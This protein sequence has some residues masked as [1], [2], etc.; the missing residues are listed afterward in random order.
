[1]GAN[2][3]PVSVVP[4]VCNSELE[5][6]LYIDDDRFLDALVSPDLGTITLKLVDGLERRTLPQFRQFVT[7]PS[8]KLHE[9]SK[10]AIGHSVQF[11]LVYYLCLS[12]TRG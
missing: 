9:R 8:Q 2:G 7:L 11:V 12:V 5:A 3:S 4:V 1:L 10:K 6:S